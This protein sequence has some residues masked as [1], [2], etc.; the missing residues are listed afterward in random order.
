MLTVSPTSVSNPVYRAEVEQA[1]RE[2]VCSAYRNTRPNASYPQAKFDA[3]LDAYVHAYP[4]IS[5]EIA[6][7][8]V[9]HIL[10]TDGL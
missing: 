5:R 6:R 4:H 2:I 1:A 3:A 10:T 7:Y 9:S 8:A